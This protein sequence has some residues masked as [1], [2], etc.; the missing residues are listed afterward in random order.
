[1]RHSDVNRSQLYVPQNQTFGLKPGVEA[2]VRVP[3]MPGADFRGAV[4]PIANALPPGTRTLLT[5]MYPIRTGC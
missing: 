5:E 1:M 2:A 3:E 4:T